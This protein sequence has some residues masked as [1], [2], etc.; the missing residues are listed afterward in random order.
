[1]MQEL[2]HADARIHARNVSKLFDA[3]V[4]AGF[5]KEAAFELVKIALRGTIANDM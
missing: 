4:A 2:S 1:M 3:Y 5:S